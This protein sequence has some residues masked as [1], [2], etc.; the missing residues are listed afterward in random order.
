MSLM[1][2]RALRANLTDAEKK[3]WS[4]LR[5]KALGY[6]FRRQHPIGPY[7]VDFICLEQRL[8]IEADGGQHNNTHAANDAKRTT[9]LND[10]HYR[11]LRFWNNDILTNIDGVIETI[12]LALSPD[13]D[14]AKD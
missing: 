9:W 12:R 3:L 14:G 10:R 1:K 7:I 2:A 5:R 13:A 11:V 8:I 6:R 4:H